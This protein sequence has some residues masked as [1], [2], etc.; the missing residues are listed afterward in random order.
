M[1]GENQS[2]EVSGLAVLSLFCF[3]LAARANPQGLTVVAGTATAHTVGSQLDVTVSQGAFLNWQSFDVLNGQTTSFIQPSA[4]SIVVNAINGT[5][6]SKIWGNLTANGTLILANAGG[7]YFGPNSMVKVGGNFVATTAPL[8]PDFGLGASWQFTGL[9]PLASIVNYGQI[10]VGAGSSLYLISKQ[11]ENDGTLAAPAGDVGLYAGQQVLVSERPDGRGLSA[12]V[13]LPSG[14]VDNA[15]RILAD[16][17]TIALQAQVVNQN[18]LIQADSVSD[19][20][21]VIELIASARLDLGADSQIFA[22]GDNTAA[23]SAGGAITLRSGDE[24]R[25]HAGSQIA[26]TGG[27]QGGDGGAIELSAGHFASLHSQMD[28]GAAPGWEAGRLLLDPTDIVLSTTG[29]GSAGTGTVL[30]GSGSGTLSLN[31]SSAFLNHNFSQIT[32]EAADDITL[33]QGKTWNLSTS[34]GVTQGQL[35][36]EAGNNIILGSNSEILDNNN[37]SVTLEAGVNFNSGTVQAGVGNI[38]L[39]GGAGLTGSGTIQLAAG[40][41][42]LTAGQSIL[43]GTGAIRT[44]AGGN[45]SLQALSG[46]INA[47]T[48]DNGYAVTA[49]GMRVTPNSLGGIATGDGGNVTLSAGDDVISI[50]QVAANQPIGASGAYGAGNVTIEAGNLVEGNFTLANGVGTITA[51]VQ[52]QNGHVTQT[53]NPAA[54]VGTSVHPITLS[55]ISGSWSAWAA[56]NMFINEVLNPNGTFNSYALAVPAGQ[57]SGN[58]D[59]SAVPAKSPF[60]FNYAPN[61]AANFWAGDA[62]TLLGQNLSR[63]QGENED[64]PP[65]YPPILSLTAGAGGIT[66][67]NSIILYPSSQGSLQI[68]TTGGGNLTGAPQSTALT[69]ITMSDSGLPGYETFAQGH[70]VTPLDVNNPSPVVL[71]I[72]GSIETFGLSVPTFANISVGGG[73]YNF[74]FQGRNLSASQ[75]TSI[76]VAGDITYRGDLTSVPLSDPLPTQLFNPAL[77]EDADVAARI[78]YNAT[79]GT[80]TFIGQMTATEE[81]FLLNPSYTT[82]NAHG[83]PVT[84]Q[85]T[86]SAAQQAAIEQLYA[87]TQNASLADQGLMLSGPGKFNISAHDIDLG[88]SGGIVVLA[89]DAALAAISPYGANLNVNVSGNLDMTSTKIANESYLGN[90]SLNVGGALDVGGEFTTFGDPSAPKG[91]FTT[92]GGNISV[93]AS[94]DVNVDGSRIAAYDG[95]NVTV[96]SAHGDVNAGSGSAGYVSMQGLE[97]DPA[98]GQLVAIPATIPGSGILA[99]TLA[100]SDSALGNITVKAPEG[101]VNASLG[102]IIQIAFNGA[103]TKNNFIEVDAGDD[104]NASGSGIIGSNIRLNAGGNITGLIVGSGTV[105]IGAGQNVT[106]TVFGE[107]GVSIA[108]GGT[109]SGTMIGPSVSVS[110]EAITAALIGDSVSASGNTT[111]ATE[112]VPQ[113]NVPKDDAKAA[114]DASQAIAEASLPPTDDDDNK[115]KQA[116]LP[117]LA[118]TTGRVTVILPPKPN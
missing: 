58:E 78:S 66:I 76:N 83:Q 13:K 37:W 44:T 94:G 110:G 60:L 63:I 20:N 16:A 71:N 36:L 111:G 82:V 112:G 77:S 85:V 109:V 72:S 10:T 4:D 14:S 46:D 65:I 87:A 93:L 7:F 108:S 75:T 68:A 96:E 51:G 1:K 35:T 3:A 99:T 61:A 79:T 48:R 12:K 50:P 67:Q 38:Y 39:N 118:R 91:I 103:N 42:N 30:A 52:V 69:G 73:T 86:L 54:D 105:G 88:I 101:S 57:F 55:L 23:N 43:V 56:N 22:R 100:G 19:Q 117:R 27:A 2:L 104:I 115:K 89:P 15:G 107:G 17:G 45:I 5:A 28:A 80:L 33:A 6:P 92:S 25:D 41:I 32:L 113:S 24:F 81:A 98:T 8:P 47:G 70:A 62:I 102:G 97:L 59:N 34:T 114:D 84:T 90:I 53:L 116:G 49:F 95:G 18:G 74:G 11:I 9:P 31:I 106:A 64:M 21:G 40:S 29:T 26:V